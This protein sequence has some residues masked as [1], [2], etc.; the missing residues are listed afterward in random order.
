MLSPY[1]ASISG[2]GIERLMYLMVV[3]VE[4]NEEQMWTTKQLWTHAVLDGCS[5]A[6]LLWALMGMRN[7]EISPRWTPYA[8]QALLT[9]YWDELCA[10][11]MPAPA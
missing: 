1:P 4:E 2:C 5:T 6:R 7:L 9:G 3:G 11:K 8:L 10:S